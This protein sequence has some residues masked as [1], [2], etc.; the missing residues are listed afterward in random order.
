MSQIE[1]Y[2]FKYSVKISDDAFKKCIYCDSFIVRDPNFFDN[3]TFIPVLNCHA[4]CYKNVK[5]FPNVCNWF[6]NEI[7][8]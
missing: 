1:K 2:H 6:S 3:S 5:K 8:F 7:P 4:I